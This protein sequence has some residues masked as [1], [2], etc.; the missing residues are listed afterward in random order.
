[1]A[2]HGLGL[3]VSFKLNVPNAGIVNQRQVADRPSSQHIDRIV[4]TTHV[5]PSVSRLQNWELILNPVLGDLE[6]LLDFSHLFHRL[7]RQRILGNF[8][9]RRV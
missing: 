8:R 3:T 7:I 9:N 1:M 5:L 4:N 6:E 2:I